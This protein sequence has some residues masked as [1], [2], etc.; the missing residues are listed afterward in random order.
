MKKNLGKTSVKPYFYTALKSQNPNTS[1]STNGIY[2][3]LKHRSITENTILRRKT[4]WPKSNAGKGSLWNPTPEKGRWLVSTLYPIPVCDEEFQYKVHCSIIFP[5]SHDAQSPPPIEVNNPTLTS[6]RRLLDIF[7]FSHVDHKF[8]LPF[9]DPWTSNC[10][11][12]SG[13][14][15]L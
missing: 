10:A 12:Y 9:S 14:E 15:S 1:T 11:F 8:L 2:N 6:V 3:K 5:C 4:L 13:M 7:I